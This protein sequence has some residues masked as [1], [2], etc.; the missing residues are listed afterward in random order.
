MSWLTISS[1][2]C[3]NFKSKAKLATFLQYFQKIDKLYFE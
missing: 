1:H 3:F 2:Y